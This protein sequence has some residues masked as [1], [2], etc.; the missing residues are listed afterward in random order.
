MTRRH[1]DPLAA[2]IDHI[3][4]LAVGGT[5]DPANLQL[6]HFRCNWRKRQT[7]G[8]HLKEQ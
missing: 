6:S 3:V 1:P 2:S 7:N 4:P 5:N 8:E